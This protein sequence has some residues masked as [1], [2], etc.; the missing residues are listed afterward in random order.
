[1]ELV[2]MLACVDW[3]QNTSVSIDD[4]AALAAN[5]ILLKGGIVPESSE[6]LHVLQ[7]LKS[8]TDVLDATHKCCSSLRTLLNLDRLL[9][10]HI[11]SSS[12]EEPRRRH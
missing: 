11:F 8:A 12:K 10:K 6:S 7:T 4:S 5:V 2:V 1:M 3:L 9:S